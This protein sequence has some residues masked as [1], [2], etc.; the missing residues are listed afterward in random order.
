MTNLYACELLPSWASPILS[1]WIPKSRNVKDAKRI[2]CA[3]DYARGIRPCFR[4]F[5][6]RSRPRIYFTYHFYTSRITL[7]SRLSRDWFVIPTTASRYILLSDFALTLESV[8]GQ[9]ECQ[10][11]E[12]LK[13]I[14]RTK[15]AVSCSHCTQGMYDQFNEVVIGRKGTLPL[16]HGANAIFLYFLYFFFF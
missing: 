2:S 7:L 10:R 14:T 4:P 3:F 8:R 6:N 11:F 5:D 13:I 15:Y 9:G 1:G 12:M 16:P